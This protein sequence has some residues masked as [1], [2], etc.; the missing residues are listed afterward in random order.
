MGLNVELGD[1]PKITEFNCVF[2]VGHV[3]K[4]E[5][6]LVQQKHVK[7]D[8]GFPGLTKKERTKTREIKEQSAQMCNCNSYIVCSEGKAGKIL[9]T[10]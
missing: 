8:V 7:K 1:I 2:F 10:M 9:H 3:D 5:C 6:K 4:K